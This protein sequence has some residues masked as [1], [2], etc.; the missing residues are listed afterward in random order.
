MGVELQY[1]LLTA[2]NRFKSGNDNGNGNIR[3]KGKWKLLDCLNL[4]SSR[5]VF[6]GGRIIC[7]GA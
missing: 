1:S 6:V 3:N 7:H 2:R 4:Y 5:Q